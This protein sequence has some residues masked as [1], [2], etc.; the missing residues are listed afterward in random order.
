MRMNK[1]KKRA[2]AKRAAFAEKQE[3]HGLSV[4]NWMF[5]ALVA[6]GVIYAVYTMIILG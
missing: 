6:L 3:K 5:A 2:N 4:I 1:K